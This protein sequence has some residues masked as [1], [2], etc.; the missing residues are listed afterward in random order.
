[1]RSCSPCQRGSCSSDYNPQLL[2]RLIK[3]ETN[4]KQRISLFVSIEVPETVTHVRSSQDCKHPGERRCFMKADQQFLCCCCT[5]IQDLILS[6][7]G[8]FGSLSESLYLKLS[9][10]SLSPH[11][12]EDGI[13]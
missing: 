11:C 10:D 6:L 5:M 13:L 8:S 1:M 3:S 2:R 4:L 12:S 9:C 7:Y